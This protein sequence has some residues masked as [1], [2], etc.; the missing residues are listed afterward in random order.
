[1]YKVRFETGSREDPNR[2]DRIIYHST[3]VDPKRP[4]LGFKDILFDTFDLA[5]EFIIRL[6]DRWKDVPSMPRY[7]FAIEE[8]EV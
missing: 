7:F 6:R 4:E 8:V 1:M 5:E 2:V 3:C